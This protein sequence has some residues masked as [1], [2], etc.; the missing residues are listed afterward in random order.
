MKTMLPSL[1][2][3][4]LLETPPKKP[5]QNNVAEDG[6]TKTPMFPEQ[7]WEFTEHDARVYREMSDENTK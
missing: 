2:V 1:L 7:P 4:S 5:V 3:P 6:C